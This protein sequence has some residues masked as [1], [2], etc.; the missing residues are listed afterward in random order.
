MSD[1]SGDEVV[2][3]IFGRKYTFAGEGEA[4]AKQIRAAAQLV[5][6]RLSHIVEDEPHRPALSSVVLAGVTLA[7]EL[8][9]L[10]AEYEATKSNISSRT[11]RLTR[12]DLAEG[13]RG[14][15][16]EQS[17]LRDSPDTMKI[18]EE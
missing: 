5:N 12:F 13:L 1:R 9:G 18:R 14:G 16:D 4:T 2:V 3:E 7:N 15:G 17:R 6:E 10:R 8:I 11:S